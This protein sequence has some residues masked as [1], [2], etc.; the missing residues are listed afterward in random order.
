MCTC[1]TSSDLIKSC[2]SKL[3]CPEVSLQFPY[4]FVGF[5]VGGSSQRK[6]W[7][8][9]NDDDVP[10]GSSLTYPVMQMK[11]ERNGL[12][13]PLLPF[14]NDTNHSF[15]ASC[16]LDG[17]NHI[18]PKHLRISCPDLPPK[19]VQLMTITLQVSE[20]RQELME[21]YLWGEHTCPPSK[22]VMKTA[23]TRWG[24]RCWSF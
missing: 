8:G 11:T 16:S 18:L 22:Y 21:A 15:L 19:W 5:A 12:S 20:R 7:V 13:P 6:R 2:L 4:L 14:H 3:Q 10:P 23:V 24:R 17:S 9:N 1:R